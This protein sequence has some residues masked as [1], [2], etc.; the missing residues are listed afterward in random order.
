MVTGQF[1]MALVMLYSVVD[2]M[3]TLSDTLRETRGVTF[4]EGTGLNQINLIFHDERALGDGANE[5][6]D[7]NDGSL[8]NKVGQSI[9]IDIFKALYIK[10]KSD[11]STLILGNAATN[12]IGLWGA[13]AHTQVLQPLGEVLILA[14]DASGVDV[15]TNAKLKIEHGGEGTDAPGYD[16]IL[17]GVD[18]P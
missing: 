5:T 16:I 14:P 18:S 3:S 7:I 11:D 9:T 13:A 17:A 1:Q 10:N 15:T 6:I 2:E 4:A 8:E 12:Q